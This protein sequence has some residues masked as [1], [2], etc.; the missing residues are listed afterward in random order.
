[1]KPMLAETADESVLDKTGYLFEPKLDGFRALLYV[2]KEARFVSRNGKDLT[3]RFSEIRIPRLKAGSCII[4]G[5]IV[6]YDK[7][8]NPDFSLLAD[9]GSAV[10]VAF[11]ILEKDGVDLRS[12]PLIERK[13]ILRSTLRENAT[14]QIMYYT[15]QGR[16]LWDALKKKGVEGV[17]AKKLDSRY[18]DGK[19]SEDW[20]KI[21]LT[22]T[23]DAIV[24]GFTHSRRTISSLALGLYEDGRII[25]VGKVG[26]GFDDRFMESMLPRL[27]KMRT[28]KSSDTLPKDVIAIRPRYVAEV[29]YRELTP[30]RKVRQAV[31]KRFREDKEITDCGFPHS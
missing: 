3:E 16:K 1:M 13:K 24:V 14:V 2:G 8:G 7:K 6:A 9:K 20:L 4:D 22:N 29:E 30:D 26:T 12:K 17:I 23:L 21:K 28:T 11:D 15:M 31:F 27:L 19:R 5:E 18:H 10:F 25:Y